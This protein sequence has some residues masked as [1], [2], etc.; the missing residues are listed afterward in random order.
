MPHR[1]GLPHETRMTPIPEKSY[2][3]KLRIGQSADL[4]GAELGPLGTGGPAHPRAAFTRRLGK[5]SSS[6]E[7]RHSI[8]ENERISRGLPV[9]YDIRIGASME[10]INDALEEYLAQTPDPESRVMEALGEGL[11]GP[12]FQAI[13]ETISGAASG[14]GAAGKKWWESTF[15]PPPDDPDVKKFEQAVA[16]R[17]AFGPTGQ[18]L[19]PVPHGWTQGKGRGGFL[20]T[21]TG[22][23]IA[24][25]NVALLTSTFGA[26]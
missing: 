17:T 11:V 4:E 19:Q 26:R 5:E 10:E 8:L 1:L 25:E 23:T 6:E 18:P 9:A 7:Q 24:E 15:F 14:V 21:V 20:E 2:L 13:G 12:T 16:D 3:D 22:Q